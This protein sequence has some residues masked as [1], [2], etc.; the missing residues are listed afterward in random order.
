MSSAGRHNQTVKTDTF[1]RWTQ[2]EINGNHIMPLD[3]AGTCKENI[4]WSQS[5][6]DFSHGNPMWTPGV[7]GRPESLD[8]V[9]NTSEYLSQSP[10]ARKPN[11]SPQSIPFHDQMVEPFGWTRALLAVMVRSRD[12]PSY[13]SVLRLGPEHLNVVAACGFGWSMSVQNASGSKHGQELTD[14]WV[15]CN[16]AVS[17][18]SRQHSSGSTITW[19]NAEPGFKLVKG[20]WKFSSYRPYSN[21]SLIR[22][23]VARI[24]CI[25]SIEKIIQTI[26]TI[27]TELCMNTTSIHL[28]HYALELWMI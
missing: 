20:K 11:D 26:D 4:L 8:C 25:W 5:H 10:E 28:H 7:A 2:L 9:P 24:W 19:K 27:T 14:D 16:P 21:Y 18:S 6:F 23:F 13:G 17:R 3:Q 22:T 15:Q 1:L 12:C